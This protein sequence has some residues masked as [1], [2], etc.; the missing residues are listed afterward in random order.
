MI[1]EV[2]TLEIINSMAYLRCFLMEILRMY[3]AFPA[4]MREAKQ[5]VTVEDLTIPAGK[6]LMVS[7]WAV[8]HSIEMWGDDADEFRVERWQEDYNGGARS[9][10]AFFTFSSGP[11]ICI[12]K[13]FA[14]LSLKIAL[15]ALVSRFVFEEAVPGWH[16][17]I[18]K[19]TSLKPMG[20]NV[21]V[22]VIGA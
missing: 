12:G 1:S 7:P 16:P 6:R 9:A 15:F 19:G 22:S 18:Q 4:M 11:R 5:S 3:P 2:P 21:K 13:D 10:Q 8:N 14:I 17:P 20:L